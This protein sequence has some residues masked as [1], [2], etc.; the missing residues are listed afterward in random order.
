MYNQRIELILNGLT[1]DDFRFVKDPMDENYIHSN[2][3]E[4]A[5]QIMLNWTKSDIEPIIRDRHSLLLAKMQSGKTGV[6]MALI[7]ILKTNKSLSDTFEINHFLILTGMNDVGLENQLKKRLREG[8]GITKEEANQIV[9]KNKEMADIIKSGRPILLKNH[10]VIIDESHYGNNAALNILPRFIELHGLDQKNSSTLIDNKCFIISVSATPFSELQNDLIESKT[11]IELKTDNNYFG[12]REFLDLELIKSS[13]SLKDGMDEFKGLL[14]S[15]LTRMKETF[16]LG[17]VVVR[18]NKKI[19]DSID[20]SLS[21]KW[22]VIQ[23]Y[24]NNI[25]YEKMELQI[26]QFKLDQVDPMYPKKPLLFLI[27]GSHRAGITIH[28]GL[29]KFIYM[30]FDT[31]GA[32]THAS[33]QGLVGR[34]CGYYPKGEKPI[35]EF[36]TSISA[37]EEYNEWLSNSFSNENIPNMKTEEI[38]I[39]E[40]VEGSYIRH[41]S[42]EDVRLLLSDDELLMMRNI[43]LSTGKEKKNK[44]KTWINAKLGSINGDVIEDIKYID[45]NLY[46]FKKN[47]EE[48]GEGVMKRFF[49][50][51]SIGSNFDRTNGTEWAQSDV[52]KKVLTCALHGNELAV[53]FGIIKNFKRV[54]K[55]KMVE[56]LHTA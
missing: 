34:M 11:R 40:P 43:S 12:P 50:N 16:K 4:A 47:G 15:Q 18:T 29:K 17:A 46:L 27:K 28:K 32:E 54:A 23:F 25:D 41:T 55:A 26:S 49:H 30:I 44:M 39:N 1:D 5:K 36:Y 3:I 37:M 31:P 2:Q 7:Y 20:D 53:H 6:F 48:Y 38:P 45:N 14:D 35:T 42:Y 51:S 8:C 19:I 24:G 10:L 22:N 9:L 52:N 21:E 13:F 56:H 33:A